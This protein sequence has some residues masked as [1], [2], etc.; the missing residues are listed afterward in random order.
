MNDLKAIQRKKKQRREVIQGTKVLMCLVRYGSDIQRKVVVTR[1]E[2]DMTM[3]RHGNWSLLFFFF[4]RG[5]C[6]VSSIVEYASYI[7]S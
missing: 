2:Q 7:K 4:V 6:Q 3:G 5:D 1:I